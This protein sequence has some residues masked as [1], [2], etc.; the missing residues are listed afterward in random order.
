MG[1]GAGLLEPNV[2]DGVIAKQTNVSDKD[3]DHNI[4]FCLF[5]YFNEISG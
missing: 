2:S 4:A 1:D 3:G 5:V